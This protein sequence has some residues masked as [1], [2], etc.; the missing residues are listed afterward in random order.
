MVTGDEFSEDLTD[1]EGDGLAE[2][3]TDESEFD[4]LEDEI[5][6]E[7][8]LED[9][10]AEFEDML[11]DVSIEIEMIESTKVIVFADN[12][13]FVDNLLEQTQT[14][15][16]VTRQGQI[17]RIL[18]TGRHDRVL[19]FVMNLTE[20]L[21]EFVSIEHAGELAVLDFIQEVICY[22]F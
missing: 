6:E 13:S 20:H 22:T 16:V 2:E 1:M 10:E 7:E 4:F 3:L 8:C 5:M 12:P 14:T 11:G 21:R 15:A 9:E 17:T 18:V 19:T